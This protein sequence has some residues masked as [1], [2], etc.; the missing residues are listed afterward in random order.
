MTAL[1]Y[2]HDSFIIIST[3]TGLIEAI[4][5]IL[6]IWN[7]YRHYRKKGQ[8]EKKKPLLIIFILQIISLALLFSTLWIYRYAQAVFIIMEIILI[9]NVYMFYTYIRRV[10]KMHLKQFLD[11]WLET[12]GGIND[13]Q[14]EELID[15]DTEAQ[16]SWVQRNELLDTYTAN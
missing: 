15:Q 4:S 5:L 12:E 1:E 16:T 13:P 3:L 6:C 11:Q 7:I 14:L 9:S 8:N 2:N 10:M